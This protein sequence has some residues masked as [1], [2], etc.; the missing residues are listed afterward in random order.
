[1]LNLKAPL[2]IKTCM[3]IYKVHIPYVGIAALCSYTNRRPYNSS[4]PGTLTREYSVHLVI[5]PFGQVII[6]IYSAYY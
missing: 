2:D 4:I 1:M 6:D 3:D 5:S